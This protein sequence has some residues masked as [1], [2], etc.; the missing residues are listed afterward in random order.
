MTGIGVQ[1]TSSI[2]IR[3]QIIYMDM[4]RVRITFTGEMR[5]RSLAKG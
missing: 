4:I 1:I 2:E 5:Y 3:M